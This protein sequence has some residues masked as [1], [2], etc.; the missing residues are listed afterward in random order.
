[1]KKYNGGPILQNVGSMIS[2][3]KYYYM[4]GT[5]GAVMFTNNFLCQ[6]ARN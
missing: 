2:A 3:E 5:V 1:M 4:V 6:G